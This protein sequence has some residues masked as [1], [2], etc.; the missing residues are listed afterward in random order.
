M[1]PCSQVHELRNGLMRGFQLHVLGYTVHHILNRVCTSDRGCPPGSLD[2]GVDDFVAIFIDDIFGAVSEEKDVVELSKKTKE[3]RRSMSYESF[4]KLARV[5]TPS[6]MSTGILVP[7]KDAMS[8]SESAPIT[9]KFADITRCLVAG[10]IA[11]ELF[12]PVELI[13]WS[14]GLITDNMA[15]SQQ[16]KIKASG[17][18]AMKESIYILAPTKRRDRT[19]DACFNTNAHLL[20]EMGLALVLARCKRG[21]LDYSGDVAIRTALNDLVP[22]L[23][24][25]LHSKYNRILILS[26]KVFALLLQQCGRP[27]DVALPSS[28]PMDPAP[29]DPAAAASSASSVK[30]EDQDS[31]GRQRAIIYGSKKG[32]DNGR[33]SGHRGKKGRGNGSAHS[34]KRGDALS[35]I[36]ALCTIPRAKAATS[37]V[38]SRVFK[39]IRRSGAS[40]ASMELNQAC[41]HVAA[42]IVRD[43]MW[44]PLTQA[45]VKVLL[46]FIEMDLDATNKQRNAFLVLKSIIKRQVVVAEVYDIMDSVLELMVRSPSPVTR[47][48]S[49]Q[50][51]AK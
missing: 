40:A 47:R 2:S 19:P 15:L 6:I 36:D 33:G 10:I 14:Q 43:C 1:P 32:G 16:G 18:K 31:G 22:A 50:V 30:D 25:G 44:Q 21:S 5:L 38:T 45:Q 11:N 4:T 41:F 34:E 12:T 48:L 23:L 9:K 28:A 39:L 42:V 20:V 8:T 7:L 17:V 46:S 37:H 24:D 35:E 27:A 29:M 13:T 26:L 51:R 49:Q 3:T